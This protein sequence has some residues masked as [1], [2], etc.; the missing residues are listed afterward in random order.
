VFLLTGVLGFGYSEVAGEAHPGVDMMV[1]GTLVAG[2][3]ATGIAIVVSYLVAI[4]T[5]RVGLDPDNHSVPIITSVMDLAGVL[6]FLLVLS[7]FSVGV[8]AGG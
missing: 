5:S 8:A 1:W 7:W 4:V 2:L 3:L 6:V